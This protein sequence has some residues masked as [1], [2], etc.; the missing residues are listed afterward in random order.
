[1]W[2]GTSGGVRC[3][4]E[5]QTMSKGLDRRQ[6]ISG[7][8]VGAG[9]LATGVAADAQS[10][11]SDRDLAP[12]GTLAAAPPAGFVPFSAPGRVVRV[13]KQGSLRAGGLYPRTDA[14]QAMVDRAVMELTGQSTVAQAWGQLVHPRDRVGIKV[15]GIALRN[16]SSNKETVLAILNGIRA[17]GVPADQIVLYDQYQGFFASTR[18]T[19][20][21]I[22]A[23]ARIMVHSNREVGAS[24]RVPSGRTAYAQAMLGCTAVINVPLIKDHSICGYTGAM[25]NMTHGSVRNPEAFHLHHASPQIAEL[26]SH[27]AIR[28]R[29]RVHITDA[30]K[31]MYDGGPLDR[32][33]NARVP[34][35][36]VFAST[37]PVATDR[38]GANIVN[39]FRARNHMLS[40]ERRGTPPD[41]I[42][43]AAA[44]GLG[45]ADPA[46][47]DVRVVTLT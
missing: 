38:V 44:L 18:I 35:E 1:V 20:R 7:T 46:R 2:D 40:L 47:I 30:F 11:R 8:A 42:A 29:V 3:C 22:P 13:N 33:P 28:S 5:E 39:E 41:Y 24:T 15:N 43:H 19:Q 16:M 12:P 26:Y 23:G 10:S 45:I 31:V 27:E 17:A 14:A 6:F 4:V 9:V 21:D 34:F 25:K 32:N 36:A 37:D